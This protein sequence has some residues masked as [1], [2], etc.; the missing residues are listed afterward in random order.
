MRMI[1]DIPFPELDGLLARFYLGMFEQNFIWFHYFQPL[2]IFPYIVPSMTCL[3]DINYFSI[4]I[5]SFSPTLKKW[6]S[7]IRNSFKQY[8]T[9]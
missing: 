2:F 7:L 5:R 3:A 4:S 9:R 6:H 8:N 1:E